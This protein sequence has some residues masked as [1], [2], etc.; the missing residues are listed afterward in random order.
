MLIPNIA[1]AL[2]LMID[3]MQIAFHLDHADVLPI[4]LRQQFSLKLDRSDAGF[5][6]NFVHFWVHDT[7]T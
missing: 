1:L 5:T 6:T 2:T 3:A 4:L 7:Q